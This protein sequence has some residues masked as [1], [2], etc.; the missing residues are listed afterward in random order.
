MIAKG[1]ER[2][3]LTPHGKCVDNIGFC[4]THG[5][6]IHEETTIAGR[7]LGIKED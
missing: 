3:W 7:G 5:G 2:N 6:E 4:W 1:T